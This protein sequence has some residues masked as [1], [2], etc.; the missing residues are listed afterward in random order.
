MLAFFCQAI[1]NIIAVLIRIFVTGGDDVLYSYLRDKYGENEPIIVSDIR[2][3]GM[4]D[5]RLRQQIMKLT[6]EGKLK[7][8]DTGIYYIPKKSIFRSGSQLS[9]DKVIEA[10]YLHS[11]DGR[12]GYY[13]GLMFANLMGLTTQVP[14][15]YDVVTNKATRDVRE[16]T[17]SKSRIIVR[18]PRTPVTEE[19]YKAL[20]FLDLLKDI[21][22]LAEIPA[23]EAQGRL[24]KYM[25]D[26]G[27]DFS[28]LE[29]YI[30]LYP[31]RIYENLYETRLLHGVLPQ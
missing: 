19:N 6:E 27:L 15:T 18:K 16:T 26:S 30:A 2:F 22:A 8:Y 9:F 12:C 5:N 24:I 25:K 29:K 10:K 28:D 3:E 20:Q 11:S 14:M 4:S 13:S 17:L 31:D 21:D 23:K 1:Y 7:R